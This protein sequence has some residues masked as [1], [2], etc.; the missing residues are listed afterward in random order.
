[1]VRV[2][3]YLLLHAAYTRLYTRITRSDL[4]DLGYELLRR[5][6]NSGLVSLQLTPRRWTLMVGARVVGERQDNDFVFGVN[7]SPGYEYVYVN[8]SWQAARHFAPFL[9]IQNAADEVYQEALGYRSL[10]RN[11]TGGVRITW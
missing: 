11:Y 9:R 3:R 2:T 8:G 1:M 6:R 5:P 10:S 4:G 7:R